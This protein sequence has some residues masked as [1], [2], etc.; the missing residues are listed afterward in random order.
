MSHFSLSLRDA[1]APLAALE[2]SAQ[3]V[4]GAVLEVRGGRAQ[5]A[6]HAQAP[7]P[8]GALTPALNAP[9]VA[10]RDAV[11]AAVRQ[12]L[13]EL[14]RPRRVGL[15]IPDPVA[16]VSLV[17]LQ[18]VP[19][20]AHDLDQVIRWQVRKSAPFSIDEAQV[21]YVP[22]LQTADGHEFIVSMARRDVVQS[23]EEVCTAAGTHAGIIDLST[24]NVA[25]AVFATGVPDG[26]WLLVNVSADLTSVAIFRGATL[27]VFRSRGADADG[28][29][30]DLVHQTAMYYE[31]RLG[32][33]GLQRVLQCGVPTVSE[34]ADL[35]SSLASRLSTPPVEVVDPTRAAGLANAVSVSSHLMEMLTPLVGMMLR[36]QEAAA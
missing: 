15:V 2:L 14:G 1:P 23:Y 21:S 36:T 9:N 17:R 22:G 7:L 6:V 29:L 16:K 24:F 13:Q 35:R 33:A 18:Q 30:A 5:V 25:N 28:S 32:G 26:D 20:R 19:A 3:R 10:D 31:D 8:E 12:V 27:V 11:L 4:S 34:A